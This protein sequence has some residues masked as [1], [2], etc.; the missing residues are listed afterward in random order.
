MMRLFPKAGMTREAIRGAYS[1]V[2]PLP[3]SPGKEH[4]AITRRSFLHDHL[5]DGTAHLITVVGGKLTTATS[6]AR[7]CAKKIGIAVAERDAM[8]AIGPTDGV[9]SALAQWSRGASSQSGVSEE[10][11]VA[12]AQWHGRAARRILRRA[13]SAP[14]MREPLCAHTAHIAAE[15]A[16]AFSE[17]CAVSLADVL[18]RRVPV[19]LGACWSSECAQRASKAVA[20]VMGWSEAERRFELACFEQERARMLGAV[21]EPAPELAGAVA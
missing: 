7:Q 19:A 18:M 5:E 9:A 15:A 16:H 13:A 14:E 17:E 12:V 6:L 1:G 4:A 11:A 20:A 10:T 3:Y 2:R 8:V 21:R